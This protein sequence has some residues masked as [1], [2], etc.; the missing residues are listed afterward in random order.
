MSTRRK[1]RV[2]VLHYDAGH[3]FGFHVV[4]V[5]LIFAIDSI[6]IQVVLGDEY[7]PAL[8]PLGKSG[9]DV[10]GLAGNNVCTQFLVPTFRLA[11]REASCAPDVACECG[12]GH[13][14]GASQEALRV[15]RSHT[16]LEVAIGGRNANLALFQNS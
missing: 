15:A 2:I 8:N 16:A 3:N 11:I 7:E 4:A 14:F 10:D 1:L 5:G 13:Y 9:K 6:G 12:G